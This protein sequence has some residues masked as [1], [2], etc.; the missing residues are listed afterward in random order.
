MASDEPTNNLLLSE[1]IR[2]ALAD[3]ITSGDLLPGQALDEQQIGDRFG[4]SRTPVREALRQLAAA[5][6]VEIRPRRGAIV[7]GFTADRIVEMFEVSAEIEAMCVRLAAWRMTPLERSRLALLHAQSEAMVASNDIDAY[8][9]LNWEFH[10]T[11]Y[12]GTHNSFL[13]EQASALRD[14]M[15][16]FRR[17]Q[18]RES[19]RPVLSR[20][21]HGKI[22]DAV[23]RS[24]GEEAARCMRAHMFNA[25]AALDR[26]TAKRESSS[27]N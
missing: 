6:L 4:A 10:R 22:L 5:N 9:R 7:A 2:I 21:E 11:I 12:L 16:A 14:R 18:L 1:R 8:D 13:A 20:G 15:A 25:S 17:T 3:D 23:M 19:G 24:D 27:E 26:L